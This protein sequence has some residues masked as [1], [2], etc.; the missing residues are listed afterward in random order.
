MKVA[1]VSWKFQGLRYFS[2]A[3]ATLQ[4]FQHP[5]NVKISILP[6]TLSQ[7]E[8]LY[9]R[10]YLMN[11][12]KTFFAWK[13]MK[14]AIVSWKFQGLRYFSFAMATLQ[15][16]PTSRKCKNFNYSLYTVPAEMLYLRKY[17]TNSQNTFFVWKI[18]EGGYCGWKFQGHRSFGFAVATLQI[19]QHPENV[20]IPILPFTLS[21][22][23]CYVFES[24]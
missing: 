5:E 19:F 1:I 12:Q 14:V 15:H 8:M 10:K 23:K 13:M 4:I 16:F 20:K 17:L 9:F 11:S 2:F 24:I 6:F 21:Q 18:D 7:A 22:Q 3:M